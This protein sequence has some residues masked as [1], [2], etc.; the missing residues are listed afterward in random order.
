MVAR[1]DS[2]AWFDAEQQV[3]VNAALKCILFSRFEKSL[4]FTLVQNKFLKIGG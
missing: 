3:H 1:Q 2:A 4:F